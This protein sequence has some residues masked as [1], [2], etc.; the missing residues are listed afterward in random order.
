MQSR[1]QSILPTVP[2]ER[3]GPAHCPIPRQR[4]PPVDRIDPRGAMVK[5]HGMAHTTAQPLVY[6]INTRCW[7]RELA[8]QLGRD[9]DGS[10]LGS[11]PDS[12]VERWR[13]LGFTHIWLMGVWPTGPRSRAA[14][15]AEASFRRSL[16]DTL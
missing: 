14:A 4:G 10:G 6:E 13:N 2:L 7:L 8:A 12:E 1:F 5:R 15:L 3:R 9:P 11:V 16:S